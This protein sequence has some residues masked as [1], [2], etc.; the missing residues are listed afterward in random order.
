M[1]VKSFASDNNSGVHPSFLRA[2]EEVNI[3][4]CHAYGSDH[5]TEQSLRE[6]KKYFGNEVDVYFVFNGSAANVLSLKTLIKSYETVICA[7]TAHLNLDECAAPESIGGFKLQTI[8]TYDGKITVEEIEKRY[9]RLG[10]QHYAQPKAISIT[11]PT[12]LGTVYTFD[13]IKKIADWAHARNMYLHMDGARFTNAV[14]TLQTTFKKLSAD[15]GVDVLSFGGTK[16]GLLYGEA[17]LFFNPELSKNFKFFRKQSLQLPSKMRF[18]ANQFRVYF[19]EEVG[20][21]IARHSTQMAQYLETLLKS[22]PQVEITQKVQSNAVFAKFPSDWLRKLRDQYFF[23]IWDE[24]SLEARWM[25][26]FDTTPED[27]ERFVGLMKSYT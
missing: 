7:E 22:V 14:V 9:I 6:F 26:S 21:Q 19:A 20:L 5:F 1:I 17:I 25:C 8:P 11:Q 3:G 24:H 2:I 23:Y 16:N 4:H 15:A 18:V 12:E 27:V 10:D 13:E